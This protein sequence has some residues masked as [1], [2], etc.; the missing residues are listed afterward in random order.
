MEE[1]FSKPCMAFF[2]IHISPELFKIHA[3]FH[4]FVPKYANLLNLCSNGLLAALQHVCVH[5]TCM[6]A[7]FTHLY[8]YTRSSKINGRCVLYEIR[9]KSFSLIVKK[10]IYNEI[11]WLFNSIFHEFL[12]FPFIRLTIICKLIPITGWK[13]IFFS[14]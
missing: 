4:G 1:N 13:A 9:K 2:V 11:T 10:K 12:K 3:R 8:K 7:C 5:F 14:F 6:D